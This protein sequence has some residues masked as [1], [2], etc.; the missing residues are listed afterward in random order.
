MARSLEMV[1][2]NSLA[3]SD[4]VVLFQDMA[5]SKHLVRSVGLARSHPMVLYSRSGSLLWIGALRSPGS[6]CVH[7]ALS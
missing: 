4:V 5:R 1:L 6:L 2:S 7:G 3:R